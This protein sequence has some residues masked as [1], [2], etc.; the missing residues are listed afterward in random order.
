MKCIDL[1]HSKELSRLVTKLVKETPP[2]RL[3]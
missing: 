3:R 2:T 1:Y